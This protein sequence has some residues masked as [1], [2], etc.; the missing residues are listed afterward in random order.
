MPI[1]GLDTQYQYRT[2]TA[3]SLAVPGRV[4]SAD[5]GMDQSAEH[6]TGAGGDDS[7]VMSMIEPKGSGAMWV[8]S[9]TFPALA[10]KTVINALPP[11]IAEMQGG[12]VGG[13]MRKHT[14]CYLDVLEFNLEKGGALKADFEWL[15]LTGTTGDATVAAAALAKNLIL[16]WHAATVLLGGS[17]YGCQSVKARLEN[18]LK[19]DTD[20]D[21][22]TA[23]V[24]RMPQSVSP[25]DSKV[26]IDV[27]FDSYPAVDPYVANP[28]TVALVVQ[29]KNTESSPKV[30]TLTVTNL[31]P[32]GTPVEVASGEDKVTFKFTAEADYNDLTALTFALA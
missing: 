17:G 29:C 1:V 20:L 4:N 16:Q 19:L 25:G 7:V 21:A 31:H 13:T 24:E 5:F 18:G 10:L 11:V 9:V 14:D 23:G 15:A 12:D 28:A 8:Q 3:G 30:F 22:K 2:T 6:L 32:L 27:E 26:S